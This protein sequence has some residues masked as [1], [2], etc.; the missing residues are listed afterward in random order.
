VREA[1]SALPPERPALR[2]SVVRSGERTV[3]AVTGELDLDT[4]GEFAVGLREA[5]AGGP[6]VLDICELSFIDSSGLRALDAVL[7]EVDREGWTFAIRRD[8]AP[9]VRQ[10]FELTGMIEL[11]PIEREPG[12]ESGPG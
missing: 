2:L 4:A 10:V 5:L 12:C 9:A 7:E 8:L 1:V 3:V 6:V 11:L